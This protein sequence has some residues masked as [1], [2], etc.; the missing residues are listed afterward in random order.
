[1]QV[2]LFFLFFWGFFFTCMKE[3]EECSSSLFHDVYYYHSMRSV[4]TREEGLS[5]VFRNRIKQISGWER[6]NRGGG[7]I[8]SQTRGHKDLNFSGKLQENE[9]RD[10]TLDLTFRNPDLESPSPEWNLSKTKLGF[11]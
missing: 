2:S 5:L 1:M 6:V 4:C 9:K 8:I 10:W 7:C 3:T 11:T